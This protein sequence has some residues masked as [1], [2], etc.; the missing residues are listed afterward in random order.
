MRARGGAIASDD[1]FLRSTAY[2]DE[3]VIPERGGGRGGDDGEV[4][5]N[6]VH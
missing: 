6:G 5:D 4:V 3:R 2:E 1:R